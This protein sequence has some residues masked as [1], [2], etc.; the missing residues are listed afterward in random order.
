MIENILCLIKFGQRVHMEKLLKYGELRFN[1]PKIYNDDKDPVRG[2]ELE[3]AEWIVNGGLTKL[4][5][6]HPTLGFHEFII[7]PDSPSKLIQFH[8]FYLSYSLYAIT[9]IHFSNSNTFQIDKRM[10]ESTNYETA[11]I[12]KQP[13]KFLN[14]ITGKLKSESYRYEADLIKYRNLNEFGTINITPFFKKEQHSY[15]NE[16]RIIVENMDNKPK[17]ISLGPISEYCDMFDSQSVIEMIW[18]VKRKI[19]NE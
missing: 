17:T 19:N 1:L 8:E 9:N 10:N 18:E 15:Q 3:G 7:N 2:D 12:I 14:E 16:Y 11:V 13:Y 4:T 6:N 5:A